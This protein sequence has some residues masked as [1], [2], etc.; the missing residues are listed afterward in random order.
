[1]T[2]ILL[3]PLYITEGEDKAEGLLHAIRQCVCDRIVP[4]GTRTSDPN[5]SGR[6]TYRMIILEGRAKATQRHCRCYVPES[7]IR[8]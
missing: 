7:F 8:Y 5:G 4:C 2:I 6:N 1:M 3:Y